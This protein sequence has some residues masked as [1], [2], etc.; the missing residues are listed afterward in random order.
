MKRNLSIRGAQD[1]GA[2][3]L[4]AKGPAWS[5]LEKHYYLVTHLVEELGELAR[6]AIN[7]EAKVRE[8]RRR[9][10]EARNTDSWNHSETALGTVYTT[11]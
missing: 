11:C 10:L 4:A 2:A 6:A 3:Y 1:H 7:L 5:G 8:P 9:G